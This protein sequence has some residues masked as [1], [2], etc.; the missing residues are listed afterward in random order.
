MTSNLT[1][2]LAGIIVLVFLINNKK[3]LEYRREKRNRKFHEKRL[4]KTARLI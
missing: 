3:I 4:K 2:A 1:A